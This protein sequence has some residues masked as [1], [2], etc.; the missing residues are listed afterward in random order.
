MDFSTLDRTD[1]LWRQSPTL[2]LLRA[3]M[4]P[5]ILF[6]LHK[7]FKETNELA[8]PNASLIS[9]LANLLDDTRLQDDDT[10]NG[11]DSVDRARKYLDD[12]TSDNY[13]RNYVDDTTKQ[14]M[15]VLT[16]HTERAFQV[17]DLLREREFVG[18]ESKF[19][20][21]FH[22]LNDIMDNS[23][24]D[25][26]QRIAELEQ[27]KEQI[28]ADIRR[29]RRDG[30]VATYDDTQIKSRVDDIKKLYN[31][32]VGDFQEVKDN[33]AHIKR[34]IMERQGQSG[35]SKGAILQYTFDALD[36]LKTSDQGRS[37]YAFWHFLIDDAGKE[38]YDRLTGQVSAVLA[39]RSIT[40]D[41]RFW[42]RLRGSLYHAGHD[43]LKSNQSLAEKLTR[44][45]AERDVAERKQVKQTIRAIQQLALQRSQ[46]TI[47][48]GLTVA[49][50]AQ[51]RMPMERRLNLQ[52]NQTT[53]LA[54]H[55]QNAD[56]ELTADMLAPLLTARR[57]D[58]RIL[59]RNVNALLAEQPVVTLADVTARYPVEQG[60][61]EIIGYFGLV[62]ET[63]LRAFVQENALESICFDTVKNTCVTIPQLTFCR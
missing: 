14:V 13:L 44:L 63:T 26:Q 61:G 35:V 47:T 60:L 18:T 62:G 22:K 56:I 41:S 30:F 9:R 45:I 32:L 10:T 48:V 11:L 21:I 19:R 46:E 53:T 3:R 24:Q 25:P 31:E 2:T 40:H 29:I 37:F 51:V 55:P 39:G 33:F 34:S 57:V 49:G 23:S 28:E 6:F 52:E 1:D 7:Q 36:E 8:V 38:T 42:H 17:I 59:L 54:Q 58:R 4:A 20:D 5:L 12:W 50:D 16:K 27:R 15:N 43:V